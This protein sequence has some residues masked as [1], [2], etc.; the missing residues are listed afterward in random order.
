MFCPHECQGLADVYGS[1]YE[2]LYKSY[3]DEGKAKQ[4]VNA[5]E[6]WNAI[7]VSQ[8]ETGTPY[9][10]YKDAVNLKTN[11]KNIG[12][13]KSSNLC[14]EIV[15][16]S[17]K[18][19]IAVCNLASVCLP[20]FVE[21]GTFD[22]EK[23]GKTVGIIT[24]NL[25]K[26][27]DRSFYPIDKARVSNERHRPIGIGVQGL[28]DV[29]SLLGYSFDSDEASKLNIEIFE[30]IYYYAMNKSHELAMKHGAYSTFEGSPLSYGKFQFDL[31]EE[32]RKDY[33]KVKNIFSG[34]YDWDSLRLAIMKHGVRNSL[35]IAPMPTATTSQIMG[36]NE[37]I[38]PYTS[39]LYVRRTIA[40]EFVIIN[41]HL[42]KDLLALNLWNT[43]LKDKIIRAEGSIQNI[44]EIPKEVKSKYKTAWEI[45]QKVLIDQAAD[46]GNF[47]CQ[48]QSLNL[49]VPRP[50]LK[51]LSSMH[52]YSWNCGLKT[53]IYYLRTKPAANP[54]QF[55]LSVN[56]CESCSG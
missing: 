47:V 11:Q 5:Q 38:E 26:I 52:F 50:S 55:T 14:A 51:I 6:L 25:N 16:Y 19:E 42:M 46:R 54:Q 32:N 13:I 18:D 1:K 45:S 35:L 27:I 30:T 23:L 40:G 12:T 31:W 34:R 17:D 4:T 28:A 36:N 7:C 21:N 29:Y 2:E 48:T 49:F 33:T 56:N 24:N 9:I 3:E 20:S 10:L 22:H 39:N 43:E 8:I 44:N 53:G 37:A 41:K 15:E